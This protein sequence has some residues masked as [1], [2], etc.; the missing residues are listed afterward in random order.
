LL[1]S[2]QSADQVGYVR[3]WANDRGV[4][5]GTPGTRDEPF[6][7]HGI[8]ERANAPGPGWPR[9]HGAEPAD[10]G[11]PGLRPQY[12]AGYYAAFIRDVDGHKIE[13]V[14]HER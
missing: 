10:E 9:A 13:A 14:C 2:T 8:G 6:A 11:G 4:G 7:L 5:Y 1:C 12:G 3:L